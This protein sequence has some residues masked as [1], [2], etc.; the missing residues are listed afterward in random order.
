MARMISPLKDLR[1]RFISLIFVLFFFFLGFKWTV[2][3]CQLGITSFFCLICC[4]CFYLLLLPFV[5]AVV[6][7]QELFQHQLNV[8]P[9]GLRSIFVISTPA[10]F[11]YFYYRLDCV[12]LFDNVYFFSCCWFF[13]VIAVAVVTVILCHISYAFMHKC[14]DIIVDVIQFSKSIN[15]QCVH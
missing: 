4:C 9:F 5:V 6:V 12:F 13:W 10:W 14:V 7:F 3:V 1:D 15:G 11:K 8:C 2:A